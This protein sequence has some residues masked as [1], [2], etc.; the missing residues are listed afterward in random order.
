MGSGTGTPIYATD[1][2]RAPDSD[3]EPGAPK[4]LVVGREGRLLDPRRTP[5]RVVGL[6]LARGFFALE[7]RAFEDAGARWLVPVESVSGYQFAP[8]ADAAAEAVAAIEDAARRF[9]RPLKIPADLSARE[10]TLH[11]LAQERAVASAWLDAQGYTSLD[12]SPLVQSRTGAAHLWTALEDYLGAAG[13]AELDAAFAATFVSN[14]RSG[15]MVKGHAIVLAELGLC[16]FD[17][18]VV[19]DPNLFGA[20][21]TKDARSRHI[22]RRMGFVQALLARAVPA[23]PTVYRGLHFQSAPAA[24]R[25]ASFI[26]AT[27]SPEVAGSNSSLEGTAS[28]GVLLKLALPMERVFMTFVETRA[29]NDRFREAEVVLLGSSGAVGA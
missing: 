26:S 22:L 7:L 24:A 21:A 27:F 23:N 1:L 13:L 5:V 11:R 2:N 17:G 9:D 28:S 8:G 18:R 20:P 10:V 29:M 3:F 12:L 19:R 14:P 6:D 25:V 4:H 16:G 15:E